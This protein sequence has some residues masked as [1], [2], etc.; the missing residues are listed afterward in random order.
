MKRAAQAG[1][2]RGDDARL[3]RADVGD[4]RLGRELGQLGEHAGQR[5]DGRAQHD[6][7][8]IA[9]PP[10]RDRRRASSTQPRSSAAA[11][12][13]RVGIEADDAPDAGALARGEAE[14]AAHQAEPDDRE[15]LD[16]AG[17]ASPRINSARR[18]ARSSDWR[19]FKR[20]SQSV[21]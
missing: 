17:R 14:R 5:G 11:P 21:M 19:A 20:G 4:G 13:V 1:R 3:G 7:L 18:K 9:R 10:P 16:H 6:E 2:H 15:A 12:R 8:G